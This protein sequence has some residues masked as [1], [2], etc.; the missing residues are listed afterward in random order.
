MFKVF[1]VITTKIALLL[2]VNTTCLT[3]AEQY[4]FQAALIP[5]A[6]RRQPLSLVLV[7]PLPSSSPGTLYSFRNVF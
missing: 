6:L 7:I 1:E 2:L 3:F 5:I 4:N